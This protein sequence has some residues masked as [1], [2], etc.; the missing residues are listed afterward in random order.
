MI[1]TISDGREGTI[2]SKMTAFR[3]RQRD[4][5]T[6]EATVASARRFGVGVPR[7]AVASQSKKPTEPS[8]MAVVGEHQERIACHVARAKT[9]PTR[10]WRMV[11]GSWEQSTQAGSWGKPRR[12]RNGMALFSFAS[13]GT[14]RR[15]VVAIYLNTLTLIKHVQMAA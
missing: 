7:R 11:S 2:L 4:H 15:N 5:A 3:C 13:H 1:A 14:D 10:M 8:G 9:Q 6:R 12:A